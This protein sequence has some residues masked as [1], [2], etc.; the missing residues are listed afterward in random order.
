MFLQ[1][2][3]WKYDKQIELTSWEKKRRLGHDGIPNGIYYYVRSPSA[4]KA[5]KADEA[6]Q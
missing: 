1:V 5:V 3:I 4:N 2:N 6:S